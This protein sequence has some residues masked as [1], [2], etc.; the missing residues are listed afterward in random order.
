MGLEKD[1]AS[2][3]SRIAGLYSLE[4]EKRKELF[5]IHNRIYE[6]GLSKRWIV[7]K[8]NP[9][10]MC[11]SCRLRVRNNFWKFYHFEYEGLKA[12]DIHFVG[13]AG[14]GSIKG[15]ANYTPI[16]TKN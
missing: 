4:S 10:T 1:I 12:T 2:L 14:G 6:E 11:G 8:E 7:K 13:R 15:S 3:A 5:A 16:Y 9:N